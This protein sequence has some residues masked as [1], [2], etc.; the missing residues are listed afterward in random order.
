MEYLEN[1]FNNSKETDVLNRAIK[2]CLWHD[3]PYNYAVVP[4]DFRS[5]TVFSWYDEEHKEV[6]TGM[7]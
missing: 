2:Y 1:L 6:M 5:V 7:C 4:N 3:I